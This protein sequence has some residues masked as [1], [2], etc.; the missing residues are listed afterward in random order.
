M[1][2][3]VAVAVSVGRAPLA[4]G[5]VLQLVVEVFERCVPHLGLDAHNTGGRE[6]R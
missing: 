3:H 4:V 1:T 5:E 6:G 2:V